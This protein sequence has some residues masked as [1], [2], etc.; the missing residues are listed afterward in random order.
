MDDRNSAPETQ[1]S[2]PAR[3]GEAVSID[4]LT[5][6]EAL[7]EHFGIGKSAYYE[8]VK[9]LKGQGFEIKTHKD[10]EKRTIVEPETVQLLTALRQHVAATS[11]REGFKYG[12]DLALADEAGTLGDADT[13]VPNPVQDFEPEAGS[14]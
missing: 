12:G 11:S 10:A 3:K 14:P 4:T 5:T 9:F 7:Q 1:N 13:P 6:P 2:G 8:D